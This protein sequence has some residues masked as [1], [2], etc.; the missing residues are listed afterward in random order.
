MV[1]SL[2]LL[3]KRT[4]DESYKT[5]TDKHFWS[6]CLGIVTP[7]RAQMS[8]IRNLLISAAGMPLDPSPFVDT[9]DRFRFWRGNDIPLCSCLIEILLRR[10][11]I[12][13]EPLDLI[14][15]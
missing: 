5:L 9:V 10:R 2:S 13:L 11:G 15:L 6:E 3:Y 8:T 1:A 14:Y 12:I 7:H 4:L